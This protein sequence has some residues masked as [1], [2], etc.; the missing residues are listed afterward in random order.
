[1]QYTLTWRNKFL[2]TQATTIGDMAQALEDAAQELRGMER[3]GVALDPESGVENDYCLLVTK[4]PEV[5]RKYDFEEADVDSE[6][7][8]TDDPND[9]TGHKQVWVEWCGDGAFV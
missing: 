7:E 4:D 2:T 8:G 6:V 1:M 9:E 3:D 5:A